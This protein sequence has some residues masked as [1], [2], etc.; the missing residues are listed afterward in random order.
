[1]PSD[2]MQLFHFRLPQYRCQKCL[3]LFQF[4]PIDSTE[5]FHGNTPLKCPICRVEYIPTDKY[6]RN[7]WGDYLTAGYRSIKLDDPYE[8]AKSLAHIAYNMRY[9][10]TNQA[11]GPGFGS[12]PPMKALFASLSEAQKFVNFTTYGIHP[13]IIGSLKVTAQKISVSGIVSGARGEVISEAT[14]S[15]LADD[16]EDAFRMIVKHYGA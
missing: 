3:A 4:L 1:M 16:D 5:L 12:W 2:L 9:F 7:Q 8:H 13:L 10:Q 11:D 14:L 6:K 15:E